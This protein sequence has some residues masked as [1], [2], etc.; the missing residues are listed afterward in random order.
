MKNIIT[1]LSF[2]LILALAGCSDENNPVNPGGNSLKAKI[3][4]VDENAQK[5]LITDFI[6]NEKTFSFPAENYFYYGKNIYALPGLLNFMYNYYNFFSDGYGLVKAMNNYSPY[7]A[8]AT[9]DFT[10]NSS[11][12]LTQAKVSTSIS[13]IY[14]IYNFS[15]NSDNKPVK[16][17]IKTSNAPTIN[18]KKYIYTYGS[19]GFINNEKIYSYEELTEEHNYLHDANGF[20]TRE[21]LYDH[22]FQEEAGYRLYF[23]NSEGKLIKEED[24]ME[25]GTIIKEFQY[26]SAGKLSVELSGLQGANPAKSTFLYNS[27]GLWIEQ[28]YY[29]ENNELAEHYVIE[30][31]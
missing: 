17:E 19:N 22:F 26:N 16:I 6:F 21:N 28:F 29:D 2:L 10:Y 7:L 14:Y 20:L 25:Y 24:Y 15:Y 5:V 12:V 1:L 27:Q 23:Y 4:F 30:Y 11:G 3:Y 9:F 8:P 31:E 13:G 18:I